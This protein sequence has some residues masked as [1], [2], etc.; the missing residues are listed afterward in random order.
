MPY[1]MNSQQ[2]EAVLKLSSADRSSHFIGKVADWEQLW[3]V[4]N[5]EGWLFRIVEEDGLEYFPVWPH[6]QYAQK[7]AEQHF[8]NYTAREI[9]LES[10]L[11]E[12]LP[13]FEKE[14]IKVGVFPNQDWSSW[15]MEPQILAE[16]LHSEMSLYE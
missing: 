16:T 6:P 15:I 13:D 12:W 2:F 14:G 1:K 3:G 5:E 8:P 7:I 11:K 4:K 9:T 10:F